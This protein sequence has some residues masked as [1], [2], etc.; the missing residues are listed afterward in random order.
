[1]EDSRWKIK[2]KKRFTYPSPLLLAMGLLPQR[3]AY[4]TPEEVEEQFH[5]LGFSG[6]PYSS[7]S[8]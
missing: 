5:A 8:R 2:I 7:A 4:L 1:M 3:T 6:S